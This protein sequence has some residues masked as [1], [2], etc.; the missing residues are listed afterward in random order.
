MIVK[1]MHKELKITKLYQ[2]CD[3]NIEIYILRY[4]KEKKIKN[5]KTICHF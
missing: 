2:L 5:K 3:K 4:F 1:I